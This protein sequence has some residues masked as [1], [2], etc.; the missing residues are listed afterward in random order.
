[1]TTT[2]V[3]TKI[4]EVENKTPGHAQ[5]ITTQKLLR[6]S[7][8]KFVYQPTLDMLEWKKI[9]ALIMFLAGNQRQ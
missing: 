3:N 8:N 1:M 4:S 9:K 6:R 5:Y 2:I 7:Q